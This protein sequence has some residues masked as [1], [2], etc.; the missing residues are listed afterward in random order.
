MEP[1]KSEEMIMALIKKAIDD[2]EITGAEYGEIMA[3]AYQEGFLDPKER[4]LL[5]E[6]QELIGNRSVRRVP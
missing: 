6:L 5:A 3:L 2:Q 4:C 1:G